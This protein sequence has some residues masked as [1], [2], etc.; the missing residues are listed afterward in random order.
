MGVLLPVYSSPIVFKTFTESHV[1]T[2]L[3]SYETHAE[4]DTTRPTA[5]RLTR[6]PL[7]ITSTLSFRRSSR[8]AAAKHLRSSLFLVDATANIAV[9]ALLARPLRPPLF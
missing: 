3:L 2:G 6:T 5:D 8:E 7:I 4:S 1:R 9:R